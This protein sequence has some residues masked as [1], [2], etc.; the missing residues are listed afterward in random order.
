LE[1][2]AEA[3]DA[4]GKPDDAQVDKSEALRIW[5]ELGLPKPA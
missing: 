2:S 5:S 1:R 4:A 3:L